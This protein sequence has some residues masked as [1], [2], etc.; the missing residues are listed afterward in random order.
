MTAEKNEKEA[1]TRRMHSTAPDPPEPTVILNGLPT[2]QD[3][4]GNGPVTLPLL[5]V[6]NRHMLAL[7][8]NRGD[9]RDLIKR[10]AAFLENTSRSRETRCT[11]T[12]AGTTGGEEHEVSLMVPRVAAALLAARLDYLTSGAELAGDPNAPNPCPSREMDEPA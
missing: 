8:I 2:R 6:S 3:K 12:V 5:V 10:L 4:H 11:V 1:D 7:T 9:A